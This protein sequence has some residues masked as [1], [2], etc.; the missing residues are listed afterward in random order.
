MDSKKVSILK[1]GEKYYKEEEVNAIAKLIMMNTSITDLDL[2]TQ[3]FGPGENCGSIISEGLKKN[4]TLRS[5]RIC[6]K[7][8]IF[9]NVYKDKIIIIVVVIGGIIEAENFGFICEALESNTTLTELDINGN[10]IA[11]NH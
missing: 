6:G 7:S 1:L 8:K 5:F 2:E 10:Q 9:K 3:D 4:S 11:K